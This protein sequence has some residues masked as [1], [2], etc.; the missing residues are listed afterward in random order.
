MNPRQ[1]RGVL[2]IVLAVVGAIGV[3]VALGSYVA[4]VRSEVGPK[5][6]VLA[7]AKRAQ[8]Q[9]PI[10]D[11][12]VKVVRMPRRWVPP[13]TLRDRISLL[14]RVASADL[15]AGSL[16]QEGLLAP[17]PSLRPGERELTI[18]VGADTG[19]AGRIGPGDYVDIEATFSGQ[20]GAGDD[21]PPRSQ[22]VVPRARIV[23]VGLPER[24]ARGRT[25]RNPQTGAA[26]VE[27]QLPVTF[28]LTPAQTLVVAYAESFAD[29]V[30]LALARKGD[31]TLVP[32]A[33]REFQ[34]PPPRNG[35]G[36]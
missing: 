32:P 14:G 22:I 2:L 19:V 31:R 28:A 15:P 4:G 35:G 1:R 8:V 17:P 18:L 12:M 24:A 36:R 25:E 26:P 5:V 30:R 34:L 6:S 3:F 16:L 9:Q 33:Q 10:T 21:T 13:G 20:G 27:A 29:E 11:D 7:L 23:A